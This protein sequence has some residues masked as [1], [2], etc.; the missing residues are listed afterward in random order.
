MKNLTRSSIL[1]MYVSVIVLCAQAVSAQQPAQDSAACLE[2]TGKVAFGHRHTDK[3][4][5]IDFFHDNT[6]VSSVTSGNNKK[7]FR[8]L[9]DRNA[10]Y[11]VRISKPGYVTRWVSIYTSLEDQDA[12]NFYKVHF[13]TKLIRDE[14]AKNLDK[15]AL[16]FPIAIIAF[17]PALGWF[18]HNEAYTASIKKE[19]YT[20]KHAQQ[21]ATN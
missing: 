16:E 6:L 11:A 19:I 15:D 8:F 9:L 4:Y 21:V 20:K 12:E 13:H 18:Y 17:D 10:Y 3:N 7:G 14:D 5:T 1:L 2:L